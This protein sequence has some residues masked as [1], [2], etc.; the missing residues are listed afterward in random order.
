MDT[1]TRQQ[2]LARIHAAAKAVHLEGEDY[3]AWLDRRTGATSCADLSDAQL[4][5]LADWLKATRPQWL[6]VGA[7]CREMGW[8]G[9]EDERF[10]T[11]V[12][13]VTKED[14]PRLLSRMQLRNL[15]AGLSN[16]TK[17]LRKR[18][19]LPGVAATP[20]TGADAPPDA[21]A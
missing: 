3:Q 4:D 5:A 13:R 16:W 1:Q 21:P 11:F 2:R 17:S 18:G 8:T 10:L 14:N 6:K 7:L 15:I 9:F 12:K 19:L 20:Q